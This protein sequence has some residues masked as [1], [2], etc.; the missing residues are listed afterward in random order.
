MA[1]AKSILGYAALAV[2][3]A[4]WVFVATMI[5]A[6]IANIHIIEW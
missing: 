5:A 2:L 1:K 4:A 3:M 6:G